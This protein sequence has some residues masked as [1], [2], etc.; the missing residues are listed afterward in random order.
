MKIVVSSKLKVQT[1]LVSSLILIFSV[2]ATGVYYVWRK[3][4]AVSASLSGRPDYTV[5]IDAGHGGIDGGTQSASGVLE[6]DINLKI[7]LMLRDILNSFG[8]KTVM[9]RETDISIHNEGVEGIRN[10]KVSDISN[11]LDIIESTPDA[12][13]VS[14][15]QNYFTQEKY[16][17]AQVF[18]SGNN[19]ESQNLALAV[20]SSIILN[21][22][23]GNTR[24]IK[25]SGK[26]IYLL[27][28]TTVPAIMLECG[29]LSNEHEAKLLETEEYQRQIAFFT[30]L[31]II[32]YIN[33]TEGR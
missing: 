24:E 15:H 21:H 10:Q 2:L 29:F 26:E 9:T 33:S 7:A 5:V 19:P 25:K 17:G 13:F 18:Y 14:I 28:H 12:L 6:K 31:G 8:I 4:M 27:R 22:Q 1:V 16:S 11:R 30:A 20:R 3:E 23:K 32:Y